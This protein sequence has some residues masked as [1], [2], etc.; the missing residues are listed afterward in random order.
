MI[1]AILFMVIGSYPETISYRAVF[2][3][4]QLTFETIQDFDLVTL[5]NA[6]HIRNCG[7]PALPCKTYLFAIPAGSRIANVDYAV[8]DSSSIDGTY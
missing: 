8:L 4:S 5:D 2:A 6:Q 1:Y 3:D 7:Y